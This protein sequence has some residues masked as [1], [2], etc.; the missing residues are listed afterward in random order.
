MSAW[1][2]PERRTTA[3]TGEGALRDALL[4]TAL[5]LGL[6]FIL[7][8][9]AIVVAY[10][11]SSVAYGVFPPPGLSWRWYANLLHQPA[12]FQAFLRSVGIGLGATALAL[13]CGT[14]GA[15]A[16]VRG[17]F[18][19]QELLRAFLLSPIVMPKIVLG[20]G[21]FIFFARAGW[22]GGVVPLILA[23]TIVVLP[24]VVTIVAANLVGLDPSL[25]EAAQ[26][27]GATPAVV[28]RRV[29]LPQI[30]G[31]LAVSGLLAFVVSFDQ[32]E[33]SIFLTR[34]E[35]NTLPIE[36]FLYMEKWQDPTIAA[37]ST[38]LI[39]F[40]ALLVAAVVLLGRG[41]DLRRVLLRG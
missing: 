6:G 15:L 5:L 26:D 38:L 21:W 40:A 29:V 13:V 7:L 39:L 18:R 4:R 16:L 14:L 11:F 36:M 35:N 3:T 20:V 22:Q 32:V 30:R 23:H 24:F 8:P 10:S 25:E 27:L 12:F 19:G 2:V 37:L 1:V 31:G 33:S 9:L 34:G 28:L 41:T 17:R